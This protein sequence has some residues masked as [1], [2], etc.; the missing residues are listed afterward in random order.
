MT[1]QP[2]PDDPMDDS[3]GRKDEP[4]DD[5]ES[6]GDEPR[7]RAGR[8]DDTFEREIE[9]E[10]SELR[11]ELGVAS[12]DEWGDPDEFAPAPIEGPDDG[13]VSDA[14]AEEPAPADDASSG[15]AAAAG[16]PAP[17]ESVDDAS[18]DA[19]AAPAAGEPAP[20]ETADEPA[21]EAAE[22]E[23]A[24]EESAE[25]AASQAEEVGF[26]ADPAQEFEADPAQGEVADVAA[27]QAEESALEDE[28][29]V[30]AAALDSEA[31]DATEAPEDEAADSDEGVVAD[32]E[33][34][35]S[36]GGDVGGEE[37]ADA[38]GADGDAASEDADVLEGGEAPPAVPATAAG[39]AAGGL[40][41]PVAEIDLEL[42]NGRRPVGLWAKF[43]AGSMLIVVSIATAVSVT[44]LLGLTELAEGLRPSEAL[45]NIDRRDLTPV[46]SGEPQTILLIGSD[47]RAG[48]NAR[49]RSDTAMLLRL[50]PDKELT[51]LFSLPR[52]LRANIP[53]VGVDRLNAAYAIGGPTLA[54]KTIR[55]ITGLD[56]NH[57]VDVNFTGFAKAVDAVDCAY[58]DVD[59]DYFNDNTSGGDRFSEIDINAG[60]QRLC[61]FKALQYVRFRHTDNDVVRGARQQDFVREVRPKIP[62]QDLVLG[63]INVPFFK[64]SEGE[65]LIEI[66]K[67]HTTSTI[68]GADNLIDLLTLL[69][70]SRSSDINEIRFEGQLG[71]TYVTAS[72][73]QM[74]QAVARFLGEDPPPAAG[75]EAVASAEKKA[76]AE[77]EADRKAARKEKRK[78][79][80]DPTAGLDLVNSSEEGRRFAEIV[81]EAGT[82][83]IPAKYPTRLPVGA[84]ISDDSRGYRIRDP[85]RVRH[86]SYKLVMEQRGPGITEYFGVMGTPW[87]DAPIL[88]NPSEIRE[89]QGTEYKLYYAGER[90]RMIAWETDQAAY[91]VNNT[92]LQSLTEQQ[93]IAIATSMGSFR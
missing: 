88:E 90:L 53:G 15:A 67:E 47:E 60:Y 35:E 2:T 68:K 31:A 50:D 75:E 89:I 59:R 76:K 72:T 54:L 4:M 21:F 16:D 5:A 28:E 7:P 82:L 73:E 12:G 40:L 74:E 49:G 1:D 25:E 86:R 81:D 34:A 44:I 29:T 71:P 38:T 20:D 36:D 63:V 24:S 55:Q 32:D 65:E 43:L 58:V 14:A 69:V 17:E 8:E 9:G 27:V 39:A 92:L 6:R 78:R 41:P 10:L 66:F 26:E 83:Q 30:E 52:D 37:A 56:I 33:A 85:D 79:E 62:T 23:P 84:T 57:V 51:S 93:M 80:R 3:Q 18:S 45:Q 87:K 48:D 13:A 46:A 70:A 91:W 22:G 61:G 19:E 77:R 64:S 42:E 11:E